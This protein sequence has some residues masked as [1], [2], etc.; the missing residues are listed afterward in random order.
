MIFVT[1]KIKEKNKF[2]LEGLRA[3]RAIKKSTGLAAWQKISVA[4]ISGIILALAGPGF[5][6]W[7]LAWFMVAP[8]LVLLSFVIV[9]LKHV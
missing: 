1:E 5:D 2:N 8:F 7:W 4:I 6:H 3:K 9:V